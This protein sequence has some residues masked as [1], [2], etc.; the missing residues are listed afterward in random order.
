MLRCARETQP[1]KQ[2]RSLSLN[3]FD[4]REAPPFQTKSA[5]QGSRGLGASFRGAMIEYLFR[6]RRLEPKRHMVEDRGRDAQVLGKLV[7]EDVAGLSE[8]RIFEIGQVGAYPAALIAVARMGA[9]ARFFAAATPQLQQ[10]RIPF[11]R[12]QQV[13]RKAYVP[14]LAAHFCARA[15]FHG[16]K[17]SLQTNQ[18]EAERR[19]AHTER[20]LRAI[21]A[22][23]LGGFAARAPFG[24]CARLPALYR[25]SRQVF[26]LGSVRSRASWQR[27]RITPSA[28]RAA[29]SW[30]TGVGAGRAGFR[31]A[32]E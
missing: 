32:R 19:K 3:S 9:P 2:S 6:R 27:Q 25:G 8:I 1:R 5:A 29:S 28:T 13:G 23:P 31:T 4:S 24:G 21:A 14:V 15:I 18:G 11:I 12:P 16:T 20:P 10:I 26:R 17:K 30:Q 22:S 7:T